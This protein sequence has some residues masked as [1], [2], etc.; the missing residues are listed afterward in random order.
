M[1]V[2]AAILYLLVSLLF[3]L[4]ERFPAPPW[5]LHLLLAAAVVSHTLG[6]QQAVWQSGGLD[7]GLFKVLSVLGLILA[8]LVLFNQL[9]RGAVN[10]GAWLLPVCAATAVLGVAVSGQYEI[11]SLSFSLTVHVLFALLAYA[12]FTVTLVYALVVKAQERALKHHHLSTLVKRLP[13]LQSMERT[14]FKLA[15]VAFILLTLAMIIGY[16]ALE[17]FLGQQVAHKTLL[18]AL[19]WGLFAGLFIGHHVWGWRAVMTLRG[20]LAGYFLLSLGFI[21]PKVVLEFIL[22]NGV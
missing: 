12:M 6:L 4:R 21:G 19:A 5:L 8:V 1:S 7:L 2:L 10:L 9:Q 16:V 18:T 20:L 15:W 22:G 3:W 11:R 14:Q 13:P 17:S